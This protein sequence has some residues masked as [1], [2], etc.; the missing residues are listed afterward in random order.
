MPKGEGGV[1][2][3]S[4]GRNGGPVTPEGGSRGL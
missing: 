1:A 2:V 4:E 3:M